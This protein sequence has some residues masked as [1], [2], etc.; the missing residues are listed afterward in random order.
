MRAVAVNS[1]DADAWII[2]VS[3]AG[4]NIIKEMHHFREVSLTTG[5]GGLKN[6][7]KFT[8]HL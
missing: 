7:A 1:L 6:Q 3:A 2:N 5:A 8:P 4:I